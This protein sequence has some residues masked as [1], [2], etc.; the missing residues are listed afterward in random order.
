MKARKYA[1]FAATVAVLAFAVAGIAPDAAAQ[2]YPSRPIRIVV[3]YPPGA[4]S[5]TLARFLGQKITDRWSQQVI[6]D[7]R[8]GGNT[9]I[10]TGAAAKAAK[11]GYTLLMGQVHNLAIAPSLIA[12]L[13]YD[14]TSDFAPVGF[15]G[16]GPLILVVNPESPA[17]S[18]KDLI[19]LAKARPGALKFPSSGNG[20][21]THLAGEMF[22]AMTNV[23]MRHVPYQ[24]GAAPLLALIRGEVDLGFD[25]IV[26]TLPH[27]KAGKLRVLAITS[28]KR[29]AVLPDV[30]TVAEAGVP[31]FEVAPWFGLVAPAGTPKEIV[32]KLS[33]E[34]REIL[35][36]AD[37]KE[38]LAGMGVET[39]GMT[40]DEFGAHIR[41]EKAK[42]TEV[43]K[44]AG[45]RAD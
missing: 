33:A 22:K 10:G 11:D 4:S 18:V 40:P 25:G 41:S 43:I 20:G 6:V 39:A 38:R 14:T 26:Q 32:V 28:A 5:D 23:D 15:I 34:L 1:G 42:W 2:A 27:V 24:G 9:V 12:N 3:T 31:G 35:N 36:L 19:A 30:P 45:V 37:V 17:K 7:N 29:S 16:F 21:S 44:T 8:P 13:P